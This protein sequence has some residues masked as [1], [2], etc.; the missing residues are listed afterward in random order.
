MESPLP[1]PFST[2][3]GRKEG[4]MRF[5]HALRQLRRESASSMAREILEDLESVQTRD[6]LMEAL[7]R[8]MEICEVMDAKSPFLIVPSDPDL[9][10]LLEDVERYGAHT[11]AGL[12]RLLSTLRKAQ[13]KEATDQEGGIQIQSE[14]PDADTQVAST[15]PEEVRAAVHP[16]K[17]E[18]HD[19]SPDP[20]DV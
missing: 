8:T 7:T 19:P 1:L 9:Q 16:M 20:H 5:G 15:S 3:L 12:L 10:L 6:Q 13:R 14:I 2:I 11:I 4:T 18:P 17:G